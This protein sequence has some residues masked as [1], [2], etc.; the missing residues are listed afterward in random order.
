[1]KYLKTNLEGKVRNLPHFRGEALLPVFEAVVNSI[2]A[3]EE[4]GNLSGGEIEVRVVRE[5]QAMLGDLDES[6]ITGFIITDNGIGFNEANFDSFE[7][8]D[9]IH[10]QALGGKGVGRFLW[11]KAFESVEIESVYAATEH[12]MKRKFA[13]TTKDGIQEDLHEETAE[14]V[15][16]IVRLRGFK[17][18]YQKLPSA[19]KTTAKIAQ[20]I[21][22]HCLSYF[23]SGEA[24]R[25]TVLDQDERLILN[26]IFDK[27]I[28]NNITLESVQLEGHEFF[29]VHIKLYATHEK[30]HNAVLCANRRDV[31]ALSL[32]KALGTSSQ[33]DDSDRRFTYAL[34]VTSAYLD[35]TV[36]NYRLD[37]EI[38]D[39]APLL[40]EAGI[41]SMKQIE[42]AVAGA[43]KVF[44]REFLEKARER[45][46]AIVASYVAN[47]NPALR[48]VP[49][50]CPEVFD[51]IEP[52]SSPEKLNEVLYR[53]KGRAEFAIRK[54]SDKLLKTQAKSIAE[55]EG[56][57]QALTA[58]ITEFQ[59]DNLVNYLCDRKRM[60]ALLEK[61]LELNADGKFPNEDIIHDLI[62]PRKSTTDQLA[63][64]DHNLWIIDECLTF[65]AF[66][67]SD[68]PL[69]QTTHSE[70]DERPDIVAFAE[71]D[72][73]K[74]ARAVSILEFKK[75]Q[76]TNFDEDPTRQLYGYLRE[77]KANKKVRLPNGRDLNVAETTRYYCYAICDITPAI[78]V[79][80]EN[81]GNYARLKGELGYYKYNRALNAHTEILHFDKIVV[82]A[83]RRHKAFFEKLGIG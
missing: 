27:D 70:S 18:E 17:K 31:K 64:E 34:Y 80:A 69:N 20:R 28:K 76:R 8:S 47:E 78:D 16:T 60:I 13:F 15:R 26:E 65:H 41:V 68:K 79:Y 43:A 54:N 6:G 2:Q 35:Q 30:M 32:A 46:E 63:F 53:H 51:E 44:L 29:L 67:A 83:K 23:I 74:I 56:D 40:T 48:S 81:D 9:S 38:P 36:D 24:P 42:G 10:K 45:K 11:L 22:E 5:A 55:V 19:Y 7:T 66:A 14:D 49:H 57:Y 58:Q 50:Y 73:D 4:R 21:M 62:F 72:D 75:P 12:R 1:M 61:K 39:D 59:K 52:N 25:V 77:I 3:I 71:V 37:F 82:D 33:F